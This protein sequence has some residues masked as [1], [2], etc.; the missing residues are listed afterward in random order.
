M[1]TD[2]EFM[3]FFPFHWECNCCKCKSTFRGEGFY[4]H[5]IVQEY[6]DKTFNDQTIEEVSIFKEHEKAINT[7][8]TLSNGTSAFICE[9]EGRCLR[10]SSH[11]H[12]VSWVEFDKEDE[13]W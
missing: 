6:F 2:N 8:K 11:I 10:C 5:E 4:L 13:V 3:R 1:L 9:V 7:I 12:L